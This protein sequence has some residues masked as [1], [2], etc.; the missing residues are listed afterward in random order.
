M[1]NISSPTP[2]VLQTPN[3]QIYTTYTEVKRKNF[4]VKPRNISL[5]GRQISTNFI[6]T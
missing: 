5:K 2:R 6:E 4:M 1:E 3:V